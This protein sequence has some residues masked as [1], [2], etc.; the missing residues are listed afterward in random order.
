MARYRKGQKVRLRAEYH[1][2][3]DWYYG[4]PVAFSDRVGKIDNYRHVVFG[5]EDEYGNDIGHEI[6]VYYDVSFHKGGPRW[7]I[8]EWFLEAM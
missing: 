4:G 2:N 7:D 6:Y 5:V 1:D 3:V 8:P